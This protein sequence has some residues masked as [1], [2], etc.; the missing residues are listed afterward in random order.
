VRLLEIAGLEVKDFRLYTVE[1]LLFGELPLE[2]PDFLGLFAECLDRKDG[3]DYS[4]EEEAE[5]CGLPAASRHPPGKD[6][7]G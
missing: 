5:G 6:H 2:R 4:A 3:G 1:F 7:Q